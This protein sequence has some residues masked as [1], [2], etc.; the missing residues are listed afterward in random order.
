V[1]LELLIILYILYSFIA[2]PVIVNNFNIAIYKIPIKKRVP[3]FIVM[4]CFVSGFFLVE[5]IYNFIKHKNIV[6][7]IQKWLLK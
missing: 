4:G 5:F 3:L 1:N 2:T 6:L 7:K